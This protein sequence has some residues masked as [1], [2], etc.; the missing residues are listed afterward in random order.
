M[1]WKKHNTDFALRKFSPTN[2]KRQMEW[3]PKNYWKMNWKV[4]FPGWHIECSAMSSK[5][6]WEQ[7]DIHHGWADHI[8][9]H[10]PN[11]I[12]QSESAYD[13]TPWVKCWMHNEFMQVN[14]WKMSKSLWT[15]YT[16]EDI[17]DRGFVPADLRY[18]SLL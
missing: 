15:G 11:E 3:D 17:I 7:F 18:F 4:G 10:H 2:E 12:A 13:V 16:L 5:Y 6:L 8:T 9:I 1:W 14:W